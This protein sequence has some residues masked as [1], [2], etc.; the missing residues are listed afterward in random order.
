MRARL[1]NVGA[2]NAIVY[3]NEVHGMTPAELTKLS[4]MTMTAAKD[5]VKGAR[6]IIFWELT[7]ADDF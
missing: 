3:V 7:T 1:L 5:S 2:N 6:N 4:S